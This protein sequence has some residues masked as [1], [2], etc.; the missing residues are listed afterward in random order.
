M[1]ADRLN[2]PWLMEAADKAL[3]MP[4]LLGYFL[5]GEMKT[6]YTIASTGAILDA[7]QRGYAYDLLSKA[8]IKKSLFCELV[9]PGAELGSLLPAIEE[10]TGNTKAKVV[11]V[12]SHD[13]ASAVLSV[14]AENS[15]FLYI[16]SGTWSLM[17]IENN[18]P[19]INYE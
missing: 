12:A 11:K 1:I 15:D 8:G 3:N 14:P 6:E 4:D 17:G 9:A 5:T 18:E 10:E 7:K 19:V 16:S 2:R 13:T